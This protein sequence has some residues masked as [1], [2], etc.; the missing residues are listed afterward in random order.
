MEGL[1]WS[2]QIVI[3]GYIVAQKRNAGKIV[4]E[5]TEVLLK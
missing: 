4:V 3:H 1:G 5:I 2:Y